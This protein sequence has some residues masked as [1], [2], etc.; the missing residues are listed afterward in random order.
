[1][2]LQLLKTKPRH[3]DITLPN[4]V[5]VRCIVTGVTI[6][7]ASDDVEKLNVA[8]TKFESSEISIKEYMSVSLGSLIS[9]WKQIKASVLDSGLEIDHI[10]EIRDAIVKLRA[11][12][13]PEEKK[14][15]SD[16]NIES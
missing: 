8:R 16:S 13:E 2:K 11:S 7:Q 1:M 12:K 6:A 5:E 4:G 14:S 9:N 15:P 10:V 3:L